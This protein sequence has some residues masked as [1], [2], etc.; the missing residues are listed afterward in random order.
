MTESKPNRG[1][2]RKKPTY[3]ELLNLIE[4]DDEKIQL[5]ERIGV[6]FMDSFA[7]G[8]YKEMIQDAAEGGQ[9]VAEH[10]QMDAAMTQA[11]A[12]E[13]VKRQELLSFMQNM[14]A[15]NS[16]AQA[17]LQQQLNASIDGQR[18]ANETHAAAIA[19][20]IATHTRKQDERDKIVG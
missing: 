18:R 20:E 17:Q 12:E 16:S 13:G 7:M 9:R 4:R 14:Q 1:L 11:G 19:Q 8:Q 10:Q 5:P 3:N 6:Q 15:A 2:F